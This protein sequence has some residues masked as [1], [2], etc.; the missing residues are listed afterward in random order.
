MIVWEDRFSVN[1][2]LMDEQHKLI[3]DMINE[4]SELNETIVDKSKATEIAKKLVAYIHEHFVDEEE[5]FKSLGDE[6]DS[7][8]H[9]IYHNKMRQ[10]LTNI[11]L[12]QLDGKQGQTTVLLNYL[13]KWW[14]YHILI[15]DMKYARLLKK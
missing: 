3:V 11:L 2:P 4:L 15:E 1:H 12:D 13:N 14:E 10:K 5:L 7:F 6:F 8:T 9:I